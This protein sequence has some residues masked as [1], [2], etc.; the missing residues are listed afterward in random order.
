NLSARSFDQGAASSYRAKGKITAASREYAIAGALHLDHLAGLA[1]SKAQSRTLDL[2]AFRVAAPL[3]LAQ[4]DARA[5]L[6][7]LLKQ[8]RV[9]WTSFV[10]SLG[11]NS[12]VADW[13]PGSR[14]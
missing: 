6:D 14:S 7:R 1:D 5:R 8:H 3:G 9:E 10:D 13:A 12:F 4:A 11:P 2:A